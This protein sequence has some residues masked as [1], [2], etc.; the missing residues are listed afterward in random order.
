VA[1]QDVVLRAPGTNA[2]DATLY[3]GVIAVEG[4]SAVTFENMTSAGTGSVTIVGTSTVTLGD[5]VST[6]CL[7]YVMQPPIALGAMPRISLGKPVYGSPTNHAK[8]I[9]NGYGYDVVDPGALLITAG[10]W[11]ALNLGSG[12]SQILVGLSADDQ[13]GVSGSYVVNAFEAYRLQVSNN[14][15]NGADGTWT[16]LVT[17]TGN[18]IFC[19]EHKLAFT[20]YS[21]LKVIFDTTT[22]GQF[23]ELDVWDASTTSDNTFAFVGDSI[24]VRSLAWHT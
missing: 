13:G 7:G 8:A 23:D 12:P 22:G 20:G 5:M 1:L 11:I 15:T 18:P 17:V 4:T 3:D 9:D 14:S 16:T 2:Q 24:T 19:R 21:W 10:D 6:D